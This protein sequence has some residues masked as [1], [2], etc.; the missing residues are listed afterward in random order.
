M[1]MP[2]TTRRWREVEDGPAIAGHHRLDADLDTRLALDTI[3][4]ETCDR[5]AHPLVWSGGQ[6]MCGWRNCQAKESA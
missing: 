3:G 1:T 2:R 4:R 6:L 5:C